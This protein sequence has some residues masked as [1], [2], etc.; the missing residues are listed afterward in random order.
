MPL[1]LVIFGIIFPGLIIGKKENR[2]NYRYV[3]ILCENLV[4]LDI[5]IR[6]APKNYKYMNNRGKNHIHN[7]LINHSNKI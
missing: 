2:L 6:I 3:K 5:L 7:F 1:R 4:H